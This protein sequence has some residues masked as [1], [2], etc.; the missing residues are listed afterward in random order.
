DLANGC[1]LQYKSSKNQRLLVEL[2][3]MQLASITFDGEKKNDQPFIIPAKHYKSA[4]PTAKQVIAKE[5]TPVITEAPV[6]QKPV[7]PAAPKAPVKPVMRKGV[8][9]ANRRSSALTLSSAERKKKIETIEVAFDEIEHKPADTF[10]QEQLTACWDGFVT[11]LQKKGKKSV[12]SV[13]MANQPEI[14]EQNIHFEVA[15]TLMKKQLEQIK[16]HLL[17]H[18][19]ESLNN[20]K[21]DLVIQV[22][23]AATVKYAYTPQEK[24][25]KLR[26]K[27]PH[28]DL[29][30]KTFDLDL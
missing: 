29:L 30:K 17:K 28:L 7:Q 4:S 15:N 16:N 11:Q 10:S 19:R 25:Q 3:L 5:K 1:D 18:I 14:Q 13:M 26:E 23:E 21:T 12:A 20:F 27:N 6:Q 22:N 2:C 8:D 9:T 24:Y